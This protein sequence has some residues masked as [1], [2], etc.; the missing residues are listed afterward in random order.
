M[1][2]CFRFCGTSSPRP[3]G[4]PP[5]EPAGGLL[6]P[7]PPPC[8]VLKFSLKIPCHQCDDASKGKTGLRTDLCRRWRRGK[9]W[10]TWAAG[11]RCGRSAAVACSTPPIRASL[12][13]GV[14]DD[15]RRLR[16]MSPRRSSPPELDTIR[17]SLAH[18][19][20]ELGDLGSIPGSCH[21]SIG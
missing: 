6:S 18:L 19:E 2:M 21:Y 11:S 12:P 5:L 16:Q 1:I 17:T 15:D 7:T 4:D 3:T 9:P 10:L 20:S 13:D 14:D 8:A